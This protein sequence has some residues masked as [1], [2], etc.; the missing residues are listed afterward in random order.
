MN[1]KQLMQVMASDIGISQ[2][3]AKIQI[4]Q[5]VSQIHKALTEGEKVYIPQFGTF[6]LRYHL[7]KNGYNPQ[8]GEAMEIPGFNQ[9]SFKAAPGLKKLINQ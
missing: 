8:T 7:A 3:Q 6:E 5:I 1:K 9:P 4:D 2:S